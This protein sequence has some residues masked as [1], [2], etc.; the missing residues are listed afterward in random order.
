MIQEDVKE[1]VKEGAEKVKDVIE[2][3]V[4]GTIKDFLNLGIHFKTGNTPIDF[5]V[6]HLLLVILAFIVYM[7]VITF[8]A[9]NYYK[10]FSQTDRKKVFFYLEG[11]FIFVVF[12]LSYN[13]SLRSD[14]FLFHLRYSLTF[15]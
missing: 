6:G 4:W 13:V 5:T 2:E 9:I 1:T 10:K 14:H 12:V 11:V 3:N 8:V 15:I 7:Y